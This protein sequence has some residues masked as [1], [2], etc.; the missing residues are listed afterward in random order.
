MEIRNIWD[1]FD[2]PSTGAGVRTKATSFPS[3]DQRGELSFLPEVSGRGAE[4]PS[5]GTM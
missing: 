1:G 5:A 3:G 2:F 4:L